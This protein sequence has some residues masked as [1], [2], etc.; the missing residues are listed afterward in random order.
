MTKTAILLLSVTTFC[1]CI[2]S[3]SVYKDK[4]Y[5]EHSWE[6]N[7][8]LI[9]QITG[10]S[11][12]D[13]TKAYLQFIFRK[14]PKSIEDTILKY[15]N[16]EMRK[17]TQKYKQ[18]QTIEVSNRLGSLL[19]NENLKICNKKETMCMNI[20]KPSKQQIDS[21]GIRCDYMLFVTGL[22]ISHNPYQYGY[23]I[24][25][26]IG[27]VA[28]GSEGMSFVLSGKH[29]LIDCNK[30]KEVCAGEFSRYVTAMVV[31]GEFPFFCRDIVSEILD[32]TP[33]Y[34]IGKLEEDEARREELRRQGY[35]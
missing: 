26:P 10:I 13:T 11:E 7:N 25:T 34:K 18:N 27:I 29:Y 17:L 5:Y 31:D 21:L 4:T 28:G 35:Q 6:K 1:S 9:T 8:L 19:A 30:E 24:P 2:P 3:Y 14:T 15:M 20:C 12:D 32:K 33:F 16:I 23:L 22:N